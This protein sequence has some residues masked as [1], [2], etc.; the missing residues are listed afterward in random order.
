MS[1]TGPTRPSADRRQDAG[2]TGLLAELQ[3]LRPKV[4]LLTELLKT[5]GS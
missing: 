3:E 2:I 5:R 1:A 4:E